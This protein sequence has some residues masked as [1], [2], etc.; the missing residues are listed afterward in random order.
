MAKGFSCQVPFSLLHPG[1]VRRSGEWRHM[2]EVA[3]LGLFRK[4]RVMDL[5]KSGQKNKMIQNRV[6]GLSEPGDQEETPAIGGL[7]SASRDGR[8]R[9]TERQN[10]MTLSSDRIPPTTSISPSNDIQFLP[11]RHL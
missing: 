7:L 2:K 1:V 5:A 11:E 3:R 6:L 8:D 9:Q 4:S 10:L